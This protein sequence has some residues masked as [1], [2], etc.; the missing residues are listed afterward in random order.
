MLIKISGFSL[1][2]MLISLFI[3]SYTAI[4]VTGLQQLISNQQIDNLT[5]S[6]VLSM[7][8]D[9]M[10]KAKQML[11]SEALSEV[12]NLYEHDVVVGRNSFSINRSINSVETD[13]NTGTE[14]KEI[15]LN[16]S[17]ADAKGNNK[18][19]TLTGQINLAI[20]SS[21]EFDE[22]AHLST[23]ANIIPSSLN[24]NDVAYFNP[25][26]SYAED[27]YVIHDSYIY[28]ATENYYI[29]NEPPQIRVDSL[30]GSTV[31]NDGWKSV[32]RLDKVDVSEESNLITL[33]MK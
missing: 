24:A 17:W 6:T 16:I 22:K 18:S 26:I 31:A 15:M 10:E 11:T 23:L 29:G 25:K 13:I 27:A 2:E 32:G 1:I 30:S 3:V 20:P 19:F 7:A 14:L 12:D 33:L 5:H 21:D 28:Q 4:N 8:T 9:R